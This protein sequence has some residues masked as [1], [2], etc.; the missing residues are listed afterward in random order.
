[1]TV[2]KAIIPAAGLGTRATP[3]SHDWRPTRPGRG[4]GRKDCRS[5]V[6]ELGFCSVADGSCG[7]LGVR[8]NG[9]LT[10]RGDG[11]PRSVPGGPA[12]TFCKGL[13]C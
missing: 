9:Y 6:L 11:A 5:W 12:G 4:T 13:R 1:M 8:H 10:S 3:G 7:G 2:K